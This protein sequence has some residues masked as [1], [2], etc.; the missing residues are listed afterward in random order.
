MLIVLQQDLFNTQ[1]V[2][3]EHVV[4]LSHLVCICKDNNLF[5]LALDYMSC[6]GYTLHCRCI[7]KFTREHGFCPACLATVEELQDN[8]ILEK[9]KTNIMR[10]ES[11]SK[12]RQLQ[13]DQC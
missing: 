3:L 6:C 11:A 10:E 4:K 9:R 2:K 12:R 8:D 1:R 13:H 5:D 7:Q